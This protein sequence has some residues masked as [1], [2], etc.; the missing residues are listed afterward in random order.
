MIILARKVGKPA[1]LITAAII[2][3]GTIIQKTHAQEN[4]PPAVQQETTT[5][6]VDRQ[7]LCEKFP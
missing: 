7:K 1:L 3:N 2:I 5:I 6:E 4:E